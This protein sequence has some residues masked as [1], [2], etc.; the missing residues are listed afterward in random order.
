MIRRRR[1]SKEPKV[2]FIDLCRVDGHGRVRCD[3][4]PS[5]AKKFGVERFL[6]VDKEQD[7]CLEWDPNVP[8]F[9]NRGTVNKKACRRWEKTKYAAEVKG[10][11][12]PRSRNVGN[13]WGPEQGAPFFSSTSKV[14]APTFGVPP[15][16]T[17]PAVATPV[18]QWLKDAVDNH[19][20]RKPGAMLNRLME[21]IPRKCLACYATSGNYTY[22]ETQ[23]AMANRL[24]WLRST[25]KKKKIE[26]MVYAVRHAGDEKCTPGKGCRFVPGVQPKYFRAF[27][28][29]D[30]RNLEDVQMWT[31]VAR[32]LPETKFWFP[33]TAYDGTCHA[34][35]E[36]RKKFVGALRRLNA[37]PNAVVRPSSRGLDLPAVKV[38]GLGPGSAV[39]E[40]EV[41][42]RGSESFEERDG[43]LYHRGGGK[44]SN[45]T[46]IC[47][48]KGCASHW[49]CPGNCAICRKCWNKTDPVVYR[50][51]GLLPRVENIQ[52]LVR[53]VTGLERHAGSDKRKVFD[54]ANAKIQ[55][56]FG[57]LFNEMFDGPAPP[58][59]VWKRVVER[60]TPKKED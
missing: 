1:R 56:E 52:R 32:R 15:A 45:R 43:K 47:D 41:A 50:R 25:P 35:P 58:K 39:V 28:S 46:K 48:D 17:C 54:A 49:I 18:L 9:T 19:A 11:P 2:G 51:H 16:S 22:A 27:D 13:K 34:T 33:T 53:K 31:E 23:D 5:T 55:D 24:E 10:K 20:L 6:P 8:H 60:A 40:K 30:F 29:G 36:Q 14:H 38:K 4:R 21:K 12:G 44:S 26:Q 3:D 37:L 59:L 57:K 42:A 7:R